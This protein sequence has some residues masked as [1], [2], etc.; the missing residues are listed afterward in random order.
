MADIIRLLPDSIANQIAAGEVVQRP[1][2]VVKELL[3]NSIDAGATSIRVIIRD[4]G[5]QLI[6]VIDNGRGMSDADARM[7]LER[8]ATSKISRADDLFSLRTMGFRGEAI[9]SIAAVSQLEIRTR[10]QEAETGTVITV[11]GSVVR[12]QEPDACPAG[13]SVSVRNLFYNIPA[14]RN[15]LKGNPVELRHIIDAFNQV[16]LAHTDAGFM[17]VHGDEVLS[18][19]PPAKLGQRIVSIFG[20]PYQQ[21]LASCNEEMEQV[22]IWGYVGRPELARRTRAEQFFFVNNR[23]IRSPYL[24][25]AVMNGFEGLLPEGSYPFYTLFI[26]IDPSLIDVNV[27]P[28]KIEIKFTDDRIVYSLLKV[29]VRHALGT[30]QLVPPLDF[31]GNI[32]LM[33][34]LKQDASRAHQEVLREQTGNS[35][36]RHWQEL[37]RDEPERQES[38]QSPGLPFQLQTSSGTG[39]A[40]GPP[41]DRILFQLQDRFI[42]REV[43]QG[44]MIIDQQ[45]AHERVLFDRFYAQSKN[46]DGSSQQLLFPVTIDLSAADFVLL[47]GMLQELHAIGFRLEPFG[48]QNMLLSGVPPEVAGR[49]REIIDGLLEQFRMQQDRLDTG[50]ADRL[51]GALARRAAIRRGQRLDREQLESLVRGLFSSPEPS[52][53]PDGQP[54]FFIFEAS[55]MEGFFS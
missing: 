4:A 46:K 1:A 25:H 8:H 51:A 45:A 17:L 27:H 30:H 38:A 21:Q 15:F 5:K 11:E 7:C 26:E 36:L 31:S 37:F 39:Q 35:N 14:R 9:A 41:R 55:R 49:E 18:D 22:R 10:Q 50:I 16:A 48:K 12:R 42:I 28:N 24:H 40:D 19:L 20:K 33:E 52:L 53:T 47:S 3:E 44:L 13:T 29:A 32:N 34:N 6:Q 2:S 23:F 43:S 54:T